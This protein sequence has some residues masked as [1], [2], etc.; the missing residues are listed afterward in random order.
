MTPRRDRSRRPACRPRL[1]PHRPAP[2]W[3]SPVGCGCER[4]SP[5][6]PR[7]A[8]AAV[9]ST[10]SRDPAV[11]GARP[12]L[13]AHPDRG[14]GRAGR[15]PRR[16]TGV[17]G[18]LLH[19]AGEHPGHPRR[20]PAA[21]RDRGRAERPGRPAV[22]WPPSRP[23]CSAPA[24][25]GWPCC[26]PTDGP[27]RPRGTRR[28]RRWARRSCDV[29]RGVADSSVRTARDDRSAYRVVAVQAGPGQALVIAQRLEPTAAGAG[30]AGDRAADRRRDRGA[31][32]RAGRVR[33]GPSRAAAGGP[34]DRG[35]RAGGGHRGP[36]SDPGGRLR[37]AGPAH[38]QLQRDAAGARRVPGAA[39]PA[40]RRRRARAAHPADLD[41]HQPGAARVGEPARCPDPARVASG[42]RSSRT[43][44][45]RSP[46]CPRWSG[47][48]SSW[49]ATTRR[50]WCTRPLELTDV[51][52][53]G[54]RAGPATSW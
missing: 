22:S 24:T 31:G 27:A 28:R 45:P 40:G 42:P 21:A 10:Q 48:W 35:D 54:A 1:R 44:R 32:R 2:R 5:N 43:S 9:G 38:A 41:A 16:R 14:A 20:E 19:R 3:P 30:Q 15:S 53:A 33:R 52:A 39:T 37:R 47:T 46:S 8:A 6:G 34:A 12:V 18:G 26:W 36:A 7:V 25:S 11:H 23:T 51:V 17:R 49:P 50:R 4:G 29:A 13:A